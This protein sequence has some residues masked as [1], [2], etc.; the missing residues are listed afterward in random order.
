MPR[1]GRNSENVAAT[2]SAS[3]RTVRKRFLKMASMVEV[4]PRASLRLRSARVLRAK[5]CP[6]ALSSCAHL[7]LAHTSCFR[8]PRSCQSKPKSLCCWAGCKASSMLQAGFRC[9]RGASALYERLL[10]AAREK[11]PLLCVQV[12][13]HEARADSGRFRVDFG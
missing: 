8:G 4:L 6:R 1:S 7:L 5:V 12:A 2:C 13:G 9:T 11:D 10:R 3:H